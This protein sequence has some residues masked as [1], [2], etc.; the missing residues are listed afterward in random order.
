VLRRRIARTVLL[1]ASIGGSLALAEL[2]W[3]RIAEMEFRRQATGF[4]VDLFAAEPESPWIFGLRPNLDVTKTVKNT[5]GGPDTVTRYRIN[6]EGFRHHAE[7]PPRMD[8]NAVRILFVGDS[9]TF[10]SCVEDDESYPFVVQRDLRARGVEAVAINSGIPG[11]NSEQEAARL[12][13]LLD[14]FRPRL[15]VVGFVVNDAEPPTIAPVPPPIVYREAGSWLFEDAKPALNA[16]GRWLVDD[17]PLFVS[18]KP[19]LDVDFTRGY[20]HGN[21]KWRHAR[22]ALAAMHR[23]CRERGVPFRLAILPAFTIPFDDGYSFLE[24]HAKVREAGE[25]EGFPVL[26]LLPSMRHLDS[27]QLVVPNDGH[28]NRDGQRHLGELIAAWIER[29]LRG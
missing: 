2:A 15:C 18:C 29:D 12:P 1:L 20:R 19:H 3:R 16:L 14:R 8:A 23:T 7:W 21:P 10:G 6:A 24:I 28:P 5:T 22:A 17:A 11:H 4:T 25:A 13:S 27:R 9:F 26:D